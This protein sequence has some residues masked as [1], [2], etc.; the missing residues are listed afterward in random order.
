MPDHSGPTNHGAQLRTIYAQAD[1]QGFDFRG[2]AIKNLPPEAINAL[3]DGISI[4]EG[5]RVGRVVPGEVLLAMQKDGHGRTHT[6]AEDLLRDGMRG[7][8][9]RD[10]QTRLTELGYTDA[11][12]EALKPDGHFGA[13][14]RAAVEAFQ[15]DRSLKDDGVAGPQTLAAVGHAEAQQE[16]IALAVARRAPYLD[17]V[18]HPDHGLFQQ[19]L[20]AVHRLDAQYGRAPDHCSHQ[21]AGVLTVAAKR[22]GLHCVDQVVLSDDASRGYAVQGSPQSPLRKYADV[23]VASAVNISLAESSANWESLMERAELLQSPALPHVLPPQSLVHQ[24]ADPASGFSPL[25]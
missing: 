13:N 20:G 19:T 7:E 21:L 14:T 23:G 22:E 12:G 11:H 3:G 10:L 6:S 1:R 5:W 2:K 18:A 4:A 8:A 17:E 25:R 9:V 16:S 24:S 15:R